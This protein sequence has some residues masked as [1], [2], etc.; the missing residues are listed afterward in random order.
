MLAV[1]LTSVVICGRIIELV[2]HEKGRH[3]MAAL[4]QYY[5]CQSQSQYLQP[6][7]LGSKVYL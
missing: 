2:Y 1:S 4:L 3:Q 7:Q 5:H 6:F